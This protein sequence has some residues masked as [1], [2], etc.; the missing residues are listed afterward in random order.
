MKKVIKFWDKIIIMLLGITGIFSG[1][2]PNAGGCEPYDNPW[3]RP[4]PYPDS[5]MVCLYGMLRADFAIR[6]TVTSKT[7]GKPIPN[8]AIVRQTADNQT[9]I[10]DFTDSEGNYNVY[11]YYLSDKESVIHLDFEDID[12]KENG[13][14][15]KTQEIKVK[16]TDAERGKMKQCNQDGGIFTKTQN[17]DL[18]KKK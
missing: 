6:G 18:K 5:M 13:G 15:F 2:K 14:E 8:I 11:D 3:N 9:V 7:D 16:I 17:V 12:G 4:S 1:C 10:M